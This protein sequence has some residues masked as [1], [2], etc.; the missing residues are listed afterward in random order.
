MSQ[1]SAPDEGATHV[2]K[3]PALFRNYSSFAGSAIAAAGLVSIVLMLLLDLFSNEGRYNPYVG[4]FTYILFPSVM[5]FGLLLIPLGMLWERRRRRRLAPGPFG[6]FPVLAPN[7]PRRRRPFLTAPLLLFIFSFMSPCGSY[8]AFEHTESVHF[9]GQPCHTVMKPEFTAYQASA[10]AR[11]RC[12]ECHVGPGAGWYVRSKL[13]GA[14]Q[15]YSVT[16]NKYPRPIKSPVHNLRPAQAPC[17]RRGGGHSLAHE[18]RQRDHLR[19]L[20]RAATGHP[21]GAHEE[22]RRHCARVPPRRL[23]AHAGAGC[24]DAGAPRG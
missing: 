7:N 16:F 9:C 12:V 18:R 10:H 1:T 21:L 17:A 11:V 6:R 2:A 8:R 19:L 13:S 24:R 5:V 15:L 23:S 20:G 3:A 4:I 14:Y 22:P